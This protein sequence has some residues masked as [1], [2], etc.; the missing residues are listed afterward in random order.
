[1]ITGHSVSGG[2]G[3][4]NGPVRRERAGPSGDALEQSQQQDQQPGVQGRQRLQGAGSE[5]SP[6]RQVGEI[7]RHLIEDEG[8]QFIV[9]GH[10]WDRVCFAKV[11]P[12]NVYARHMEQAWDLR[13]LQFGRRRSGADLA[14]AAR[15]L[16]RS[17]VSCL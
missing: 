6:G 3:G 8:W 7:M 9:E 16:P 12:V 4:S 13:S 1:M 17:Q 2:D 11:S 10:R 14:E 15:D 5:Q